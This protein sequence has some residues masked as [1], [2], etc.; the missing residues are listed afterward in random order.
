MSD[1]KTKIRSIL[2]DIEGTTSSISFVYDVMFPYVREH[3]TDF[4][5]KRWSD[6]DVQKCIGLLRTDIDADETWPADQASVASAVI[7]LMD[8][9]VKATGLKQLQG[10]IW[11][12]GFKSGAM[13]AHLFDDVAA[14]IRKWEAAGIDVRIYSSGSIAAQKLFFEHTVSGNLLPLLRGHYDTTTGGKKEPASYE[15]IAGEIGVQPDSILFISDV[16]EE[17]DAAEKAGMQT[18]LSVR[19]GNKPVENSDRY[20]SITDFAS[21][22]LSDG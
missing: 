9:D 16:G 6:E 17:L 19:P 14:A 22:E 7:G 2:L 1:L 13:V 12:D 3:L 4:L 20:T 5:A 10:L 21:V 11:H 18:L 8:N 15:I